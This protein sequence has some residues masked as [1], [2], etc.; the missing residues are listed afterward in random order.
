MHR[1]EQLARDFLPKTFTRQKIVPRGANANGFRGGTGVQA[2]YS[3]DT[4]STNNITQYINE[5]RATTRNRQMRPKASEKKR[6]R[7]NRT[8]TIHLSY[9]TSTS[10]NGKVRCSGVPGYHTAKSKQNVKGKRQLLFVE[11]RVQ[12]FYCCKT[13]KGKT[14]DCHHPKRNSNS[15]GSTWAINNCNT[16]HCCCSF[17]RKL[18]ERGSY[19]YRRT[20]SPRT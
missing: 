6:S 20:G 2:P 12:Q 4:S 13:E 8:A 5:T 19:P 10:R 14:A 7:V 17:V 9:Y 16:G 15:S 3:Y 1:F 18:L 11:Y